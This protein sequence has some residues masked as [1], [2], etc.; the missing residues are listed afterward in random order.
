MKVR[1][2][3]PLAGGFLILLIS[4]SDGAK[5]DRDPSRHTT[6]QDP[7]G[8][9]AQGAPP[10][11]DA[12][13]ESVRTHPRDADARTKLARALHTAGRTREALPHFEA[14]VEFA[15][16]QRNLLDLGLAYGASSRIQEADAT[17]RRLLELAP[18]HPVALHNLGNLFYL[19]GDYENSLSHY[20]KA[21]E[22]KPGYVQ[23]QLHIG[24][25]L[26]QL[27]QFRD[28]YLAFQQVLELEPK[29]SEDVTAFDSALYGMASLDIMMGAYD[30]AGV[31]LSEL[32][33]V[34]PEHE[35][36]HY[37]LG[38]VLMHQ[39]REAEAE[40]EFELHARLLSLRERS[41]TAAMAE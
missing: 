28:A 39:G 17:Y 11:I 5:T 25:A 3:S 33:Q 2:L 26:K 29:S 9:A 38:Q 19:R 10:A 27:G 15:P 18:D 13:E 6:A 32:V 41:G 34:N 21:L 36:A 8:A 37:A 4:C 14:A 22:A 40:R 31:M 35:S 30:R 24:D 7:A 16:S 20:R 12:L 23:A 1:A